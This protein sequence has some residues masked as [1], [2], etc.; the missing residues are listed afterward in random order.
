MLLYVFAA[1]RLSYLTC[2]HDGT[3][4]TLN[5][6]DLSFDKNVPEAIPWLVRLI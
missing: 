5:L 1:S 3:R 2:R 6:R 4:G